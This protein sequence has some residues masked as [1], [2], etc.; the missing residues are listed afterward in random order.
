MFVSVNGIIGT[1]ITSL[2]EGK[3]LDTVKDVIY[4]P[5]ENKI[6]AFIVK[7]RKLFSDTQVL[8][9]SSVQSIGDDLIMINSQYDIRKVSD[10]P[11]SI[12]YIAR[13]NFYLTDSKIIT[14]NGRTLGVITD[15]FFDADTGEVKELEVTERTRVLNRTV[16]KRVVKIA[17]ILTVG[18]QATIIRDLPEPTPEKLTH[19]EPMHHETK[20]LPEYYDMPRWHFA[21]S[22]IST[23]I[24][25]PKKHIEEPTP[26]EPKHEVQTEGNQEEHEA[27]QKAQETENQQDLKHITVTDDYITYIEDKL[28]HEDKLT[29]EDLNQYKNYEGKNRRE[30]VVGMYLTKNILLQNDNFFAQ[31]GELITHKM[32]DDAE[33]QGVLDQVLNNADALPPALMAQ[34]KSS[35]SNLV[36]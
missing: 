19:I 7:E 33:K 34:L 5:S 32:L 4:E 14:E 29:E 21:D 3:S 2:Q 15:M 9:F 28:Q 6:T 18:K 12:S 17:D 13:H 25:Q 11:E 16:S 35:P 8:P 22:N 36:Q 27:E 30:E 24:D 10:V 26:Y 23:Q 20:P 31:T 1:K